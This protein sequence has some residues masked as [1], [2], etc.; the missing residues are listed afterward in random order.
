MTIYCHPCFSPL[1]RIFLMMSA[2]VTPAG[3]LGGS[4][5]RLRLGSS[6]NMIQD[7]CF[8]SEVITKPCDSRV[9]LRFSSEKPLKN[10]KSG[11]LILVCS[12]QGTCACL[13]TYMSYVRIAYLRCE[14]CEMCEAC[15]CDRIVPRVLLHA[16]RTRMFF[17]G[18]FRRFRFANLCCDNNIYR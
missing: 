17:I 12:L 14:Q 7:A 10:T 2:L 5:Y 4:L 13:Y 11:I 18:S 15:N 1:F 9:V 16:N 3:V 6:S 8:K